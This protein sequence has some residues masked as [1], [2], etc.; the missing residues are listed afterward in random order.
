LFFLIFGSEILDKDAYHHCSSQTLL[1][2]FFSLSC[3]ASKGSEW[4]IFF[5]PFTTMLVSDGIKSA[6][7]FFQFSHSPY[8]LLGHHH[9]MYTF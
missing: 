1:S 9:I 2:D 4:V 7:D 8:P 6:R 3:A 5:L